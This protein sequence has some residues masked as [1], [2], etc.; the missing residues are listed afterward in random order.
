MTLYMDR[1]VAYKTKTQ[2]P[3][4]LNNQ[5]NIGYLK[6]DFNGAEFKYMLHPFIVKTANIQN[7]PVLSE[8]TLKEIGLQLRYPT[9]FELEQTK[10]RFAQGNN[11]FAGLTQ[12][13]A[14]HKLIKQLKEQITFAKYPYEQQ[15]KTY[16]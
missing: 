14:L 16:K 11:V 6:A 12:N 15:K 1:V 4:A 7:L 8:T 2:Y 5:T 9:L 3:G 10:D 13:N